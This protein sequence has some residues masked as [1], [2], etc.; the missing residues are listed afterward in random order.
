MATPSS[1]S[2]RIDIDEDGVVELFAVSGMGRQFDLPLSGTVFT[3]A[4][5]VATYGFQDSDSWLLWMQRDLFGWR[6]PLPVAASIAYDGN[7]GVIAAAAMRWEQD[8]ALEDAPL[9]MVGEQA[10]DAFGSTVVFPD[11]DSD[12]IT[13]LV[14]GAPFADR[15]GADAGAIYVVRGPR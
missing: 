7:R 11:Y 8:T 12:S 4:A 10:G 2:P 9:L 5:T 15:G 1:S 3:G 13:D 6:G 14:V